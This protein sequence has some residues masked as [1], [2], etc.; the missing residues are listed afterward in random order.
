MAQARV[1]EI[2]KIHAM[3]TTNNI[4]SQIVLEKSGFSREKEADT[5]TVDLNGENVNFV[6]YIWRTTK[7]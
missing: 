6:H 5:T 3:T 1:Y 4:A 7:D 2:N